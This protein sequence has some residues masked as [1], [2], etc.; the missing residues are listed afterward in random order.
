LGFVFALL[1]D[2]NGYRFN[3]FKASGGS[4]EYEY[5]NLRGISPSQIVN[6]S[7]GFL[8]WGLRACKIKSQFRANQKA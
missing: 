1:Q 3:Q 7:S 2:Q 6:S 5:I 4:L 8:F